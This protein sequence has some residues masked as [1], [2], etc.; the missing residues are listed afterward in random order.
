MIWGDFQLKIIFHFTFYCHN[1]KQK[2]RIINV[3]IDLKLALVQKLRKCSEI[4]IR[5][6]DEARKRNRIRIKCGFSCAQMKRFM[7]GMQIYLRAAHSIETANRIRGYSEF[8]ICINSMAVDDYN[9]RPIYLD[10]VEILCMVIDPRHDST[11]FRTF[12][13]STKFRQNK[14]INIFISMV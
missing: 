12:P 9:R 1:N 13:C 5:F 8:G 10:F 6:D 2:Y 3:S 4:K 11:T 14:S 7:C